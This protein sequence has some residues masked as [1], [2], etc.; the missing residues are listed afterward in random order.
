MPVVLAQGVRAAIRINE[1][2]NVT[3]I[4]DQ[5]CAKHDVPEKDTVIIIASVKERY[6]KRMNRSLL[7]TFPL[8]VPDGRTINFDVRQ[9]EQ[10]DLI[11]LVQDYSLA[12]RINIDVEQL[13]NIAHKKLPTQI[14]E[15]P[16]DLPMQRRIILR[17]RIGDEPRELVEAFCEFFDIDP[18]FAGTNIL[19]AVYRGLNPGAIVVPQNPY[20]SWEEKK[21]MTMN[22]SSMEK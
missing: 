20:L 7:L 3:L 13:A 17:V 22:E 11:R 12:M 14:M 8:D 6:L 2:E 19:S 16:V 10:H 21:N 4:A 9:G 18:V 1:G 15:V 5:F